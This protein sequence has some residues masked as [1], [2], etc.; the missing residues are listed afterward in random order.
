MLGKSA[1]DIAMIIVASG[2]ALAINRSTVKKKTIEDLKELVEVLET[3]VAVQEKQIAEKDK[4]ICHLEE[5]IDGNPELVRARN[6]AGSHGE[7]GRNSATSPEVAKN[8]S[9]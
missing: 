2:S 3:R 5:I 6:L 4:R 9:P 8:G 7:S 1:L